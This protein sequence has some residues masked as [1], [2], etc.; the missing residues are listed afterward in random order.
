MSCITGNI[1]FSGL[2]G[3]II[4]GVISLIICK[5]T[6]K[7]DQQNKNFERFSMICKEFDNHKEAIA[8]NSVQ[9][10]DEVSTGMKQ[11]DLTSYETE[12]ILFLLAEIK[13]L[14]C[15]DKSYLE[16]FFNLY[17]KELTDLLFDSKFLQKINL[18]TGN[19]IYVVEKENE[20]SCNNKV[21]LF[22]Q[23][24]FL[25]FGKLNNNNKK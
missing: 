20:S 14:A 12:K 25:A 6:L 1:L 21:Y 2:F 23:K 22:A 16:I 13:K 5:L 24:V 18:K 8:Q 10:G 15:Y 3:S 17:R 4:G 19:T 9:P 11:K 7:H